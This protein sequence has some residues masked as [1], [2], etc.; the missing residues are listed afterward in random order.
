M[1]KNC[2][3]LGLYQL[4]KL[5]YTYSEIFMLNQRIEDINYLYYKI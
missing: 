5:E 4:T 2:P 1:V 3:F